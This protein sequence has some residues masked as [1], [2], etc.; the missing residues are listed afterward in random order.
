MSMR[1]QG[2]EAAWAYADLADVRGPLIRAVDIVV[3][4]LVVYQADCGG[5]KAAQAGGLP[6]ALEIDRNT[7][8]R[9]AAMVPR[10]VPSSFVER[11]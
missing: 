2:G 7:R 8:T 9:L 10:Q 6:Y 4:C 3:I 1:C 11:A 5:D